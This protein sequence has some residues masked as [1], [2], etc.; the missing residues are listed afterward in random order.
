MHHRLII[1]YLF[2]LL[3]LTVFLTTGCSDDPN[4]P[5]KEE[6]E[7]SDSLDPVLQ[8]YES[9]DRKLGFVDEE[10]KIVIEAKFDEARNFNESRA[11]VNQGG[12]WGY[13]DPHGEIKVPFKYLGA[14]TF[15]HGMG[16]VQS[17]ENRLFGYVSVNG[18]TVVDITFDEGRDFKGRLAAVRK[19]SFWGVINTNGETVI[20]P[21]YDNVEVLGAEYIAVSD[22]DLWG[23]YHIEKELIIPH[24]YQNIYS[25]RG[26]VMRVK[27]AKGRYAYINLNNQAIFDQSY[28]KAYD[29]QE[30]I[31]A[32]CDSV[33]KCYLM[34]RKGIRLSGY[35]ENLHPGNEGLFIGKLNGKWG[36]LGS[37]GQSL[38]PFRYDL[39]YNFQEGYA[40]YLKNSLW[41]YVGANGHVMTSPQFGLA[42]HFQN[43]KARVLTRSG[44]VMINKNFETDLQINVGEIRDFHEGLA[45]FKAY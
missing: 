14:W 1:Q 5:S 41:G 26:D 4:V 19:A 17:A 20:P 15:Q 21:Q 32:V 10:G 3:S 13:V 37:N 31:F 18:D 22:K 12:L 6:I 36:V 39:I 11:A 45:A 30:G 40:P 42:W 34:D 24:L 33:D 43:G 23:L 2:L 35:Y 44:T 16:R 27:N 29:P 28:Y 38:V 9:P 7:I 8:D 25:L